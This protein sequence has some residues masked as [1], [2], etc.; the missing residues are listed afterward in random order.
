[1]SDVTGVP[2][3]IVV[4]VTGSISLLALPTYLN[5]FYAAGVE[6]IGVALTRSAER[7]IPASTWEYLCDEVFTDE[8]PGPGHITVRREC[9]AVLVMPATANTLTS[10]AAGTC[11]NFVTL[12]AATGPCTL[13]PMMNTLM[14]ERPAVQRA[15]DT[16]RDDGHTVL[17]P[18]TARTF[19]VASKSFV[20]GPVLPAPDT[21]L[22]ALAKS[23][24]A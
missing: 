24:A 22:A 19:E 8:Q 16:V 23:G 10:V 1:M 11:A 18:A 15:I 2:S 14:W 6:R 5:Y 9:D 21:I 3:R 7:I 12:L 13:A 20:V 4:C 17:L